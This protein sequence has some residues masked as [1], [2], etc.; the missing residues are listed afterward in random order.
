M[1]R[2]RGEGSITRVGRGVYKVRV[3]TGVIGGKRG[4]HEEIVRGTH[5]DAVRVLAQHSIQQKPRAYGETVEHFLERWITDHV[6][7]TKRGATLT[8]HLR[9]ITKH[10]VPLIGKKQL[11]AVGPGDVETIMD[12]VTGK[13]LGSGSVHNVRATLGA[14]WDWGVKNQRIPG[15][16]NIVRMTYSRPVEQREMLVLDEEQLRSFVDQVADDPDA[17]FFL[18]GAFCGLRISEVRGLRWADLDL[19][20]SEP[21]LRV[22]KQ[23]DWRGLREPKTKHSYRRL[24]LMLPVVV[25]LKERRK[26][27]MVEQQQAERWLDAHGLIFTDE[28]GEPASRNDL[29]ARFRQH[30]LQAGLPAIRFH[31]LRHTFATY[32][33]RHGVAVMD[34]SAMLGHGKVSTTYNLYAHAI[35]SKQYASVAAAFATL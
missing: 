34:V 28:N 19:R 29:F 17:A 2:K 31:D 26:R 16:V 8:N 3:S 9:N 11:L 5:E 25:A 4:R 10:I 15:L 35:P 24:P 23:L 27:Q 21:H 13:G 14:A 22:S 33:L 32:M 6:V 1:T 12:A 20:A 7:P 18:L 30:L